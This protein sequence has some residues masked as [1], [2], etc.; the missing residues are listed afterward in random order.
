MNGVVSCNGCRYSGHPHNEDCPEALH[1]KYPSPDL[2]SE[3]K[4]LKLALRCI[5]RLGGNLPDNRLTN[6]TGPNDAVARGLMY[7]ASRTTA[8]EALGMTLEELWK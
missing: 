7:A 1:N 5:A 2:S 4:K 8:L 6:K 3:N